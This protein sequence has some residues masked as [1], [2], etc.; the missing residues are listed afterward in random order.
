MLTRLN[1]NAQPLA[2][3]RALDYLVFTDGVTALL[4]QTNPAPTASTAL[5]SNVALTVSDSAA[6]IAQQLTLTAAV[7]GISPTR[8]VSF[9]SGASSIGTAPV[10][11]GIAALQTSFSAVGTYVTVASYAGDTNNLASTSES[12]VGLFNLLEAADLR[13]AAFPFSA[14][15]G[16]RSALLCACSFPSLHVQ[17]PSVA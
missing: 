2:A 1:N 15:F 6:S 9:F 13:S 17:A 8:S 12:A 7:T 14:G 5:P 3:N 10:V 16:A 4:N 11:D